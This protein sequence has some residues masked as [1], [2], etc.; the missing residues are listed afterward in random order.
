MTTEASPLHEEAE[1]R[2]ALYGA[3]IAAVE[4][5]GAEFIPLS[6]RH[7]RPLSLFWTWTSPNFEF[8]TVFV[9]VIPVL[10]FGETFWQ[11]LLAIVLG[12]SLGSLAQGVLSA[13]GPKYGMA[14]M[15]LSRISFGRIGNI[16][17][18][19]INSLV[20]GVGWFAVN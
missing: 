14:Q 6:E 8:A 20:A 19:G 18:A 1:P 4:P 11:A 12:T 13:R 10:F 3:S 17:P 2:A 16:L 9:G 7:G 15:M 5:G